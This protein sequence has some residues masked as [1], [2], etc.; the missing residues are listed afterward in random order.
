MSNA[1]HE[2]KT[3]IA[4]IKSYA[5]LIKRQGKAKPEVIEESVEKEAEKSANNNKEILELYNQGKTNME[6]AKQLGLGIG[7]VKL[8]IDLFKTRK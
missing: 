6:I 1:S 8:V 5:Q 2:L 7:E 4:I 3:P